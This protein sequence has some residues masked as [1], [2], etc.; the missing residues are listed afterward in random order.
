MQRK[1]ILIAILVVF[2]WSTGSYAFAGIERFVK[3]DW[4]G[5]WSASPESV[6]EAPTPVTRFNNVTLRQIV[7]TSIGG[8]FV[9]LRLSNTFGTK[10]LTIGSANIARHTSNAAIEDGSLRQIT[11]GG[12]AS[13]TIPVGAVFLSDPVRLQ[14]S[15]LEDL[16]ISLYLPEDTGLITAHAI[17]RQINYICSAPGDFTD[18]VDGS[19]FDIPITSWAFLNGVDVIPFNSSKAVVTLGDS[20]TDGYC[21]SDLYPQNCVMNGNNRWPDALAIRLV[22]H[23]IDMAVL[24]AGI[25][26]NRLLHGGDIYSIY[27]Q[28]AL[29][30]LDRDVLVQTGVSHII[31]LEGLNDIGQAT[32]LNDQFVTVNDLI[33]GL[34]Q[35]IARAHARGIKV[36]GGT[37]TPFKGADYFSEAN[38]AIRQEVNEWIL[39]SDEFDGV[40]D[41]DAALRNPEDPSSLNP[42]YDSGDHLHPNDSGYNAMGAAINLRLLL[43]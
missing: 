4:V 15:A 30:R 5:T 34:R 22:D 2:F 7:H 35:I 29:S 39:T 28:A 27:G 33:A 8:K 31:V 3:Q 36:I 10:P 14:V 32:L 18:N 23:G 24:N 20:I 16:V 41:F 38:E 19:V 21:D 43:H 6:I 13:L 11:F 37:L 9:R 42:I 25:T 12:Q 40:V 26:G 1:K 17:S